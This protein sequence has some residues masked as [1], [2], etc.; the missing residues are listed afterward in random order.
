MR[1]QLLGPLALADG[2]DVVVLQP[3]K[4]VI[5]LAALLLNA[6]STVSAEYLQ[7]AVW[8]EDQPATA[9]AALQTCVLRL[10]RLFTKHGVTGTSIEAVPGGYRITAGPPTLDLLG[11]RDQVRRAAALAQDPEAELYT[12]KDAL[13]L[14]QGSLLA[15]VRSDV[16]HRDEVPRLSE[17]RLRAVER[18]CDLLLGLGRCGE[19]LVD[20]WTATRVYPGHERFHEQLIEALYR[21]GR[22]SQALAEY[23]RVKG[24]L[25]DELGVD[26]SPSLRQLELSILRGED[27]GAAAPTGTVASVTA[28]PVT[29]APAPGPPAPGVPV[30]ALEAAG[31]SEAGPYPAPAPRVVQGVAVP[32]PAAAPGVG[33]VA[34]VPH[35]T[36]RAAEAEAMAARLTA[37]PPPGTDGQRPLAVLVSGAPGIGKTALAQH[38]AHLVRDSFPAGRLLVRMTRA[39]GHPRTADE[40]AADVAAALGPGG[41][42]ATGGTGTAVGRALLILDDVVDADQVRPLLTPGVLA[43]GPPRPPAGGTPAHPEGPDLAVVVT[44]RMGL[45]GLIATHGGWV[46]RLTAFTEAESYAFLLA[47]LGAERVEAEQRAARRLATL[48][49]HFP[50]ALRILTARLLTRPGLRLG[51]AVDWLGD[52]PLARLTLTDSPDHSV[53]GLFDRALGRLDPRLSEALLRIGTGPP[54]LLREAGGADGTE[55]HDHPSVPEDVLE[56]LAD[57][58]LLEDGPPGPYRVHDL[59]RAHLRRT[60]RIRN[61]RTEKV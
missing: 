54:E 24:F 60:V 42:G 4:P 3:S 50:A 59:L 1:F 12:L 36:G 23:R 53:S 17:E 20:L 39:D 28:A 31:A 46:H 14:W 52:D 22:Q 33:P 5:L 57:A 10:R 29:A 16:L 2:P 43:G 47:A 49:G 9:K 6:N 18:V 15:N 19:A 11:F 45:G 30:P 51:D 13:S 44:S 37:E 55:D 21:T 32:L 40:V 38:V 27:L 25:L 8:G 35:F 41:T 56:Q 34:A 7:R 61:R 58:G 48:C 26:P